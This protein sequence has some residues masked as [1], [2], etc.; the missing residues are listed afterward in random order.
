MKHKIIGITR[1]RNEQ[2]IIKDCLDHVAELVD[3]IYVYDD[4]STD[5]T[6]EICFDH[7]AVKFV[8][9]NK[10]WEPNPVNRAKLEGIQR[11][12]IY[13]DALRMSKSPDWVYYFDADEFA[14]F[15]GIN[16]K[17]DAYKLRLFDFYITEADKEKDWKYREW[18]GPE[19]RDI[20]MLFRPNPKIKFFSRTPTLLSK[21]RVV[22]A[23]FVKHYGKA[24]S[25]DEWERKCQY[26]IKNLAERGIKQRWQQRIGKA[27]HDKSDFNRELIRWEERKI[28][29]IPLV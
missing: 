20:L 26:Y 7:P 9:Q 17:A 4:A 14:D 25:V 24:I 8:K 2:H 11:Q 10:A 12:E 21:Y 18:M 16:F 19:Y 13:T 6:R 1:I 28:K 27:I 5:H 15:E 22:N 23:G 29:G 3:E